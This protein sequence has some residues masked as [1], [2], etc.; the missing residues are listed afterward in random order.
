[1]LA[2]KKDTRIP[3][4]FYSVPARYSHSHHK[5][6]APKGVLACMLIFFREATETF[7]CRDTDRT[8]PVIRKVLE[9]GTGRDLVASVATIRVVDIT[10]I[11][12]LATP[13]V[14]S[15]SHNNLL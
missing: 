2:H 9:F 3:G 15:F 8:A 1:M 14:L 11:H 5:K 10:A 12:H 13:H 4:V 6:D 7:L